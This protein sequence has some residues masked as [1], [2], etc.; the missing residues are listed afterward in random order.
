MRFPYSLLRGK[1]IVEAH[2]SWAKDLLAIYLA[3]HAS[4]NGRVLV[5]SFHTINPGIID[6]L[7]G[8][9]KDC[10]LDNIVFLEKSF[11]TNIVDAVLYIYV[12]PYKPFLPS[13]EG[14]IVLFV[15]PRLGYKKLYGWKKIILKRIEGYEFLLKTSSIVQR[16]VISPRYIGYSQGPSGILGRALSLLREGVVEYGVLSVRDAIDI[17][18]YN[19]GVKRDK[20]RWILGELA[21]KKYVEIRKGEVIVY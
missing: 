16:V 14:N 20:A 3:L 5:K 11:S 12:D 4:R 19:I 17:I 10:I 8:I 7:S 2:E 15:K 1:W 9:V 13:H 18:A 6:G 21:R